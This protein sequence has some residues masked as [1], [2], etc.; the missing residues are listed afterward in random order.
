MRQPA[1]RTFCA[2]LLRAGGAGFAARP[3]AGKLPLEI[4]PAVF[5]P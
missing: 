5:G 1:V 3:D 2:A 4:R